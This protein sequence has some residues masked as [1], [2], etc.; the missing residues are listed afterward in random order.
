MNLVYLGITNSMSV[1]V[2]GYACDELIVKTTNGKIENRDSSS[3]SFEFVADSTGLAYIEVYSKWNPEEKILVKPFRV[4]SMPQPLPRLD[5]KKGGEIKKNRLI[6]QKGLVLKLDNFDIS[7]NFNVDSFLLLIMRGEELVFSEKNYGA[8][9]NDEIKNA[10]R[11]VQS[12]DV[13]IFSQIKMERKY[14]F[15]SDISPAEFVVVE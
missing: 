2:E 13:L 3:C 7:I 1:C 4:Y 10:L 11:E 15:S 8:S 5:S 6:V 9:F 14:H 12:G